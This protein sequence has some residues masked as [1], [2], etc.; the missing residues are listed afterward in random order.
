M[1]HLEPLPAGGWRRV[2]VAEEPEVDEAVLA[3]VIG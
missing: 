1:D 3:E 2:A